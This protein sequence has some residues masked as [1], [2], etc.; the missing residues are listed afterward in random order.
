[1]ARWIQDGCWWDSDRRRHNTQRTQWHHVLRLRWHDCHVM[2]AG[3]TGNK[4]CATRLSIAWG[5][6]LSELELVTRRPQDHKSQNECWSYVHYRWRQ[7][8]YLYP[9]GR[10]TYIPNAWR[11]SEWNCNRGL[12]WWN[13]TGY[14]DRN[15]HNDCKMDTESCLCRTGRVCNQAD[16]GWNDGVLW[17]FNFQSI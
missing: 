6:Y 17:E 3:R 16:G 7:D 15:K 10:R 5:A 14:A 11:L 4:D 12:G 1:M 9:S 2:D 8:P 13:H